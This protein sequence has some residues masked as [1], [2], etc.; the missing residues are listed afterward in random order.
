MSISQSHDIDV[1]VIGGGIAGLVA[2]REVESAGL[3]TIVLEASDRVGGRVCARNYKGLDKE[4]EFG[5][6]AFSREF[7]PAITGEYERYALVEVGTPETGTFLQ[8]LDGKLVSGTTP[9]PEEDLAELERAM[10]HWLKGVER[11]GFDDP[12]DDQ[13]LE[14]LDISLADYFAPLQL[15][16]ATSDHLF[17]WSIHCNG[18]DPERVS[19][20]HM[21]RWF[22]AFDYSVW[23]YYA[24]AER[25]WP[26][27]AQYIDKLQ[28]DIEGTVRTGVAVTAV[29]DL[30]GR[31]TV[32]LSD[33]GTVTAGAAIV[34]TPLNA[35]RTIS[36]TPDLEGDK[37]G[38]AKEGQLGPNNKVFIHVRNAPGKIFGTSYAAG[39]GV[40]YL[41]NTM[42]DGS[43]VLIAFVN[44]RRLDT[45]E[46]A[47]VQDA[48][49][50]IM[51]EVEVL[52][53]D[54]EN[55]Q[56]SDH[57]GGGLTAFAPGQLSRFDAA[58]RAAHGRV[59]FA[60]SDISQRWGGW[61]E[62]AVETATTAAKDAA[63]LLKS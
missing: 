53:V 7:Q 3:S 20:L 46:P 28:H 1:A 41:N 6:N 10:H 57:R 16:K 59:F 56:E 33:G 21:M 51:P 47:L 4:L 49:R 43:Q 15:S 52:S 38:A 23:N 32:R 19:A 18:E 34:A 17:S 14:D 55:W 12:F 31:V 29:E 39:I 61:I 11:I 44:G 13:G 35:W 36:F 62:G 37:A 54:E 27:S 26:T 42:P 22:A 58:L 63:D 2:A 40:V 60:G 45:K 5:G 9:V 24:K 48:L 25:K 8:V 50:T 30:D